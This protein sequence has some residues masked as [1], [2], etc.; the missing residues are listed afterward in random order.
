[1]GY[2]LRTE[3][4]RYTIWMN[5][6]TTDQPFEN[7]K[8]FAAELYDYVNDPLEK[9]NVVDDKKYNEISKEMKSNMLQFFES[10]LRK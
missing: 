2:S 3:K 8:V 5:D 9:Y 10:Q 7:N 4:Y 1:M 6:Y